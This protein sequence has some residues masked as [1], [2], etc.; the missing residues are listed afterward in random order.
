[1]SAKRLIWCSGARLF[2]EIFFVE[3]GL[4]GVETYYTERRV[5]DV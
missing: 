2:S 1:M 4:S 5:G 3:W